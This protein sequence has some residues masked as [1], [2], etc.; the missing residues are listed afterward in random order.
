MKIVAMI[1]S[2]LLG[3]LSFALAQSSGGSGGSSGGAN[4]GSAS[5]SAGQGSAPPLSNG[6]QGQGTTGSSQPTNSI[7]DNRVKR[8]TGNP[9]L[10]KGPVK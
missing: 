6:V 4:G 1:L 5:T 7:Y 10:P 8:D 3:S 2:V 9:L